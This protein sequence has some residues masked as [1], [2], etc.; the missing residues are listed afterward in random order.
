MYPTKPRPNISM[1]RF[2]MTSDRPQLLMTWK[3][4]P[5]AIVTERWRAAMCPRHS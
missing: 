1:G 5:A 3:P 2:G 4:E